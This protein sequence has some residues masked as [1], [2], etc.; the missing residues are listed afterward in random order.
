LKTKLRHVD[1]HH[2]WL[3]QEVQQGNIHIAWKPTTEMPADGMTKALT[4]PKH[5]EFIKMLG[6][7]EMPISFFFSLGMQRYGLGALIAGGG[8]LPAFV[9]AFGIDHGRVYPLFSVAR[10][11]KFLRP[12][13][14]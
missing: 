7:R 8:V 3:R 5:Q 10:I 13:G 1:I 6:L 4:A 2:H 9:I 11:W 12:F 14:F